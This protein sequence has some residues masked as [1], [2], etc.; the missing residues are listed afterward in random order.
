[1]SRRSSVER[2]PKALRDLVGD[3]RRDGR[4]IDEILAKLRE[5]GADAALPSRSALGRHVKNLD[6]IAAEVRRSREVASAL[7]ARFGEE[8]ESKVA[9]ANIELMHTVVMKGLSAAAD[10]GLVSLDP[11]EA[12][13][14]ATAL[15]KLAQAEKQ[16]AE[17]TLRLR[18]EVAK[19]AAEAAKG[20]A[21]QRGLGSETAD[22]IY[23]EVLG[24]GRK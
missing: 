23:R 24:I 20:A 16:D 1:M 11:Q 13:F 2:L 19:E 10:G 12:M 8:P 18:R 9:R 7:V 15:Q 4:T 6:Q 3:L 21:R 17:R 22:F 14:M 5:L